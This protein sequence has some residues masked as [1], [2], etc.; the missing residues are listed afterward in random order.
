M[1]DKKKNEKSTLNIQ[2]Q[3]KQNAT[4]QGTISWLEGNKMQRFRSEI[5]LFKLIMEATFQGDCGEEE[6]N[7]W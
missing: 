6:L 2:V 1:E 5:E 3:F 4:W 7:S